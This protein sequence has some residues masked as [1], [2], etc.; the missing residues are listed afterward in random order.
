MPENQYMQ[1]FFDS[2]SQGVQVAQ[3]LTQ[4]ALQMRELQQQ[5]EA[6][7]ARQQLA[8]QEFQ[9]QQQQ[10]L[11]QA[12]TN[13][14]QPVRPDGTAGP[15]APR[16][17]QTM[18]PG[19]PNTAQP[20]TTF[21]QSNMQ[22][23]QADPAR[24]YTVAGQQLQAPTIQEQLDR[25]IASKKAL[26]DADR[27]PVSDKLADAAGL[28][29]GTKVSPEH[30]AGLG[31]MAHWLN[32]PQQD[33]SPTVLHTQIIGDDKGN[34]T[35]VNQLSDGT[36]KETP[37]KAKGKSDKFG[38][39]EAE[40]A[41]INAKS[42]TD[43]QRRQ[44]GE[45]ALKDYQEGI[46]E[47]ARL[48]TENHLIASALKSNNKLYVTSDGKL[49]SYSQD[50]LDDPDDQKA[51]QEE[52][53]TRLQ[54]NLQRLPQVISDRQGAQNRYADA[55]GN[56]GARPTAGKPAAAAPAAPAPTQQFTVGQTATNPKTKQQV[57]WDGKA[58]QPVTP[59]TAGR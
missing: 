51:I 40:A 5:R 16:A 24:T 21:D 44:A 14:A 4:A 3:H 29:R 57:R 53:K 46:K 49:R 6:E 22:Q 59:A 17:T 34:Q 42:M 45:Q 31:A 58:W 12:L 1:P 28:P 7:Q 26:E 23:F 32:P 39:P 15:G 13:G 30:L 11:G 41:S 8:Q 9:A 2:L 25:Q 33:N 54:N 35:I 19:D 27:I 56:Q 37:L 55:S 36:V 18:T 20:V 10:R 43:N 47:E 38:N 52:M 48:N 50:K